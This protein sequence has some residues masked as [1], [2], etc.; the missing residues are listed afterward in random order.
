MEMERKKPA[1]HRKIPDEFIYKTL[2]GKPLYYKGYKEAIRNHQNPES[3]MG[4]S[5]LQVVILNYI[6][7][8]LYNVFDE[9]KFWIF[10]GEPIYNHF[11]QIW[12]A[13]I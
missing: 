4:V 13:R 10:F 8:M 9:Q 5:S 2:D 6:V 3:I 11:T 12:V 1:R 7:R